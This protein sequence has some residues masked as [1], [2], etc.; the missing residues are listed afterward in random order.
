ML[1]IFDATV[2]IKS[3]KGYSF[4]FEKNLLPKIKVPVNVVVGTVP[5]LMD[6]ELEMPA[7]FELSASVSGV[8][9]FEYHSSYSIT[10]DM[11]YANGSGSYLLT[12]PD[13]VSKNMDVSLSA[14]G[15]IDAKL[16]LSPRVTLRLYK[17][18]GPFVEFEAYIRGLL[19]KSYTG[20]VLDWKDKENDLYLGV[21]LGGGLSVKG[22]GDYKTPSLNLFTKKWDIVKPESTF[23]DI[24]ISG[25]P[26]VDE[27]STSSYKC[28]GYRSNNTTEDLTDKVEWTVTTLYSL[29]S[30]YANIN[31]NC[32]NPFIPNCA[33]YLTT[34]SVSSD[35]KIMITATYMDISK[36]YIVT[37]KD[38]IPTILF[39]KIIG[40]NEVDEKSGSPYR[41]EVTYTNGTTNKDVTQLTD[42]KVDNTQYATI[43]NG[44]LGVSSQAGYLT[45][46]EVDTDQNVI[47]TATYMGIK[48]NH[49]VKI[50]NK[51]ATPTVSSFSINNGASSTSTKTVT[52]NNSAIASPTYYMASE[53]SSFSGASWQTY[54]TSPSF[55]LSSGNGTKTVYFKVKNSAGESSLIIDTITLS[56]TTTN[57]FTN[58][59]GM[60][61][62]LIPAGT[63]I[64]G[65]PEHE[66]GR[67]SDETQHQVTLTKSYYMQ[68]TEVTDG[69]WEAIMGSDTLYTTGCN[70]KDKCPYIS[71]SW[72]ATQ[73]FIKKLNAMGQGT[74][75]LPTEAQWEYAA[76]AGSTTALANGDIN[77]KGCDYDSNL[78]SIGWYCGNSSKR[79][80]PVAQKSPNSWGLYDMHGNADEW[81]QDWYGE[82]SSFAVTDPVGP[83]SGTGTY[84]V[85][86][87]NFYATPYYAKYCRSASRGRTS[88]FNSGGFRLIRLAE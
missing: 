54:S 55:T 65:S 59:L 72:N 83:S 38:S 28:T 82:Y 6:I 81:C 36:T 35:Q 52:L 60:T 53:S 2:E 23:T 30:S 7:K 58:S 66:L 84:R 78:D 57:T 50:K 79:V 9:T 85:Y 41:C 73:T 80:N 45:T 70:D 63:F 40:L 19:T 56:E 16:S 25:A 71:A 27:Q 88:Q 75:S 62:N 11:T 10:L 42:W 77:V 12:P 67:D 26:E 34:S 51:I 31:Y 33:A 68:T 48:Q 69:Q 8:A 13:E 61:F 20:G 87:S 74:Y 15:G 17:V 86:R 39:T 3:A 37:I 44:G 5:V 21:N 29:P 64:M 14:E 18:I 4:D 32:G 24:V 49:T 47:I 22:L 76:R 1:V 43:I 46:L